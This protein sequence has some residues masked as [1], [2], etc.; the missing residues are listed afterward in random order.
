MK[1]QVIKVFKKWSHHVLK[2]RATERTARSFFQSIICIV[3]SQEIGSIPQQLFTF[4]WKTKVSVKHHGK[5]SSRLVS[6]IPLGI[7]LENWP[8]EKT[9]QAMMIRNNILWN[10]QSYQST[11]SVWC[12][13]NSYEW[14]TCLFV[15]KFFSPPLI[16]CKI[17]F[18]KRERDGKNF[19]LIWLYGSY[20]FQGRW[21]Y[22]VDNEFKHISFPPAMFTM[23]FDDA[24]YELQSYWYCYAF[25]PWSN[26]LSLIKTHLI[27]N[28]YVVN[29]THHGLFCC[30]FSYAV[31]IYNNTV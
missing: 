31:N 1:S 28:Q 8:R 15:R 12:L 24:L 14:F 23:N 9:T 26:V 16:C 7:H 5:S 3:M 10:L 20:Q 25:N 13:Q 11:K 18:K 17:Y 4:L 27:T 22:F 19:S 2:I 21:Q 29:V 30:C 6:S